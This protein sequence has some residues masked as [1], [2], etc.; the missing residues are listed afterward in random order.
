MLQCT[1]RRHYRCRDGG[2]H[3][4]LL[5]TSCRRTKRQ[6]IGGEVM[7]GEAIIAAIKSLCD[8]VVD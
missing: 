7:R 4:L 6:L 1:I 3:R 8:G 5:D 2:M